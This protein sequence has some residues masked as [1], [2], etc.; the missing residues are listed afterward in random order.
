MIFIFQRQKSTLL[1]TTSLRIF[2]DSHKF[3]NIISFKWNKREEAS[4]RKTRKNIVVFDTDDSLSNDSNE[5]WIMALMS[6]RLFSFFCDFKQFFS[7]SIYFR[8]HFWMQTNAIFSLS[9]LV[10]R[11]FSARLPF[12][13]YSCWLWIR[14]QPEKRRFMFLKCGIEGW[15]K[16]EFWNREICLKK[17]RKLKK[18]AI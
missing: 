4:K 8:L 3:R 10:F 2:D 1:F 18:E 17:D 14:K 12:V 16:W 7:R 5:F 15:S 13:V 6:Q 9:L 11:I